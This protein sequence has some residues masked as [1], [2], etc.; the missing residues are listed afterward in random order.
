MR[1][2]KIT[3][4]QQVDRSALTAME[5][6]LLTNFHDMSDLGKQVYF[7]AISG[8]AAKN[9]GQKGRAPA[10]RLVQGGAA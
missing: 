7:H 9:R 4:G 6:Q 5:M 8:D 10:L 2:L 3:G 1:Q